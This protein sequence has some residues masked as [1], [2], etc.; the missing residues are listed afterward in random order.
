MEVSEA[1]VLATERGKDI[2]A[3][4]A[5]R[6]TSRLE[7]RTDYHADELC[8]SPSPKRIFGHW[9]CVDVLHGPHR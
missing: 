2:G 7:W 9:R 4:S 1:E 8:R 6:T 3:E 5:T